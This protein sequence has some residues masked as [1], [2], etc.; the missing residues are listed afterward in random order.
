[1]IT[2][3]MLPALKKVELFVAQFTECINISMAISGT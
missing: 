2:G 3:A 1:M